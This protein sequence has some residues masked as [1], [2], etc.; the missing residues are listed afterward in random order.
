VSPSATLT[1]N[2]GMVASLAVLVVV[3][4]VFVI[5]TVRLLPVF[6]REVRCATALT[7]T[8]RCKHCE[9][10]ALPRAVARARSK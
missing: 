2:V 8:G 7:A 3:W 6:V 4:S 10:I 9:A 5:A 1:V